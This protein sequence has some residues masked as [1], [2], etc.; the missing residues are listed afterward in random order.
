MKLFINQTDFLSVIKLRE[1]YSCQVMTLIHGI[2]MSPATIG[3]YF[4]MDSEDVISSIKDGYDCHTFVTIENVFNYHTL[5]MKQYYQELSIETEENI[6]E[7]E[8]AQ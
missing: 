7:L 5:L 4:S 3:E 6:P 8:Y 1:G 2:G